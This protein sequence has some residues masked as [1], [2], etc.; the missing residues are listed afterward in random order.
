MNITITGDI[1]SGKS[2]VSKLLADLLNMRV[3]DSGTLY[4][5]YSEN[6]GMD[7]LQQN[8]SDD[9]SIDR[10]I[11][12]KIAELGRNEDNIIFVSRLAWNFVPNAVKIYLVVNPVTA[13]KRIAADDSRT[14]ESHRSWEE[15]LVYNKERKELELKRYADMYGLKDP[16]GLSSADIVLVVGKNDVN[17]VANS[18]YEII[19]KNAKGF[20]IDPKVML[21]TQTI[22]DYDIL[23]LNS[24][25]SLLPKGVQYIKAIVNSYNG[26]YYIMDGHHRILAAIKLKVPYVCIPKPIEVVDKPTLP[27]IYDYEDISGVSFYDEYFLHTSC[28]DADSV[29]KDYRRKF[30]ITDEHY[31]ISEM[32]RLCK[33]FGTSDKN[34]LALKIKDTFL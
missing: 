31:W 6:K 9:W 7:V 13:A 16:S 19:Q 25:L 26:N 23:T 15:T 5:K 1:G 3:V 14:G 4:R 12:N 33:L 17:T 21:P 2:T 34:V 22:R 10:M 30:G 8:K 28:S 11:D 32:N 29:F 20:Y 24:Y 27:N 18:L